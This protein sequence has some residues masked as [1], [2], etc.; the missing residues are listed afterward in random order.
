LISAFH[1]PA[2]C[3]RDSFGGISKLANDLEYKKLSIIVRTFQGTHEMWH[4]AWSDSFQG[5]K[6]QIRRQ[7]RV[8]MSF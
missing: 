5:A 3:R 1:L 4:A 8:F 7:V 2:D 6:Q